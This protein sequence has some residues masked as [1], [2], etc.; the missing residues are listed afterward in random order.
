MRRLFAT[1]QPLIGFL[2]VIEVAN[3][4]FL[5]CI[6]WSVDGLGSFSR[7]ARDVFL[8]RPPVESAIDSLGTPRLGPIA[9]LLAYVVAFALA[10]GWLRACFLLGLVGDS[11]TFR[12]PRRVV[13]R[14]A[15]YSVLA[16]AVFLA[17]IEL[18]DY[19]PASAAIGFLLYLVVAAFTL[20]ADYA[21][22]IDDI[23]LV[24]AL[25]RSAA[26]VRVTLALSAGLWVLWQVVGAIVDRIFDGG[27]EDK[28]YV[29]P[30]YLA[31]YLVVL[32]MLQFLTDISLVTVYRATPL[33]ARRDADDED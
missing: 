24:A 7:I 26:A 17:L 20:Y 31:A 11:V 22:V 21:I 25:A 1:R 14:L 3:A 18:G 16:N 23:G 27:F 28:T 4:A 13:L 30:T 10:Q 15:A 12:P 8:Q 9:A 6:A 2:V 29:E 19:G 32:A 33:Q 5:G